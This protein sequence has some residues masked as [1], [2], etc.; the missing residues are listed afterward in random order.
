M[1]RKINSAGITEV[2]ASICIY[3]IIASSLILTINQKITQMRRTYLKT[4][5][6][7]ELDYVNVLQSD[8]F[9]A[10]PYSGNS[11]PII[12]L[13]KIKSTDVATDFSKNVITLI[14]QNNESTSFYSFCFPIVLYS[15]GTLSEGLLE[16]NR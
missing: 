16:I 15:N 14:Y 1:K 4:K 11:Y 9:Y 6:V 7:E 8:F 10:D 2:A 13:S 5:I 3:L 12:D